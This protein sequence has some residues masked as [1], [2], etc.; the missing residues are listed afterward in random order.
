MTVG[1]FEVTGGPRSPVEHP[2][3]SALCDRFPNVPLR[4]LPRAHCSYHRTAPTGPCGCSVSLYTTPVAPV[5]RPYPG[6][7]FAS[8]TTEQHQPVVIHPHRHRA[9][10]SHATGLSSKKPSTKPTNGLHWA[11]L[12]SAGPRPIPNG[13][14]FS[15]PKTFPK[16]PMKPTTWGFRTRF[17]S[18]LPAQ[19]GLRAKRGP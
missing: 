2:L 14:P 1:I 10:H 18:V 3:V 16:Q 7:W 13:P 12:P 15:G 11:P 17:Q 19:P 4:P 9:C 8:Q 6:Q 5:S